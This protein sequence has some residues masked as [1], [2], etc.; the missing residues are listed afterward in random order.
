M[1]NNLFKV[2]NK[3][4]RRAVDYRS[5]TTS[6]FAKTS[7]MLITRSPLTNFIIKA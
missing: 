4:I 5:M 1:L 7:N 3:I 2:M 6:G